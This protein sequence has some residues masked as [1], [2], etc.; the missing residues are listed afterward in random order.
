LE[1]AFC[2]QF[3]TMKNGEEAYIQLWNTQQQIVEHV[4]VYY[5]HLLKL[6]NCLH[7]KATCVFLTTVLRASDALPSSLI[8]SNVNMKWNNER[9]RSQGHAPYLVT[10][11]G[12]GA[13]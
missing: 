7:V 6:T 1:Q 13:C 4:E 3:K 5:E 8:D 12:R 11:W 2:K 10:H 9:I